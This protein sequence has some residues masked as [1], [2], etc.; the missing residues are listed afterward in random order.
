MYRL[1][2]LLLEP[3]TFLTVC[4]AVATAWAWRRQRPRPR[5]LMATAVVLAFL[6]V[7]SL[8]VTGYLAMWSLESSYPPTDAVPA[9]GDTLVVLSSGLILERV[10]PEQVRLDYAGVD[11]C[12][13]AV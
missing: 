4:L 5:W 1:V 3:F 6:I 9:S 12:L 8:P 2:V 13:H 7:L 10:D 11:R